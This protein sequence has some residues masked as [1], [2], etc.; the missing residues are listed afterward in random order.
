VPI[1]TVMSRLA[2]ARALLRAA[3]LAEEKRS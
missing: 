2:R 3:W 1:G